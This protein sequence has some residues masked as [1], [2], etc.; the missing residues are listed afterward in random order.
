MA[1]CDDKIDFRSPSLSHPSMGIDLPKVARRHLQKRDCN[2]TIDPSKLDF[3][4]GVASGDPYPNSVILWIHISPQLENGRFNVTVA[5]TVPLYPHETDRY[6]R[7]STSPICVH[8]QDDH[9]VSSNSYRDDSSS[10]NNTESSFMRNGSV[11]VDQRKMN[12]VRAYF[13]WMPIEQNDGG[14][15][16]MGSAQE[17]WSYRALTGS[18]EQGAAW[19][20]IGNQIVVSRVNISSW[21][22]S[23]EKPYNYNQ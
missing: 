16:L 1:S 5:G 18:K 23:E 13:E 21:F 2:V 7:A 14:R 10:L 20:V 17:N 3:T 19:R 4:H 12:A 9:D 15:S 8:Y 22:G 6:I 11:S